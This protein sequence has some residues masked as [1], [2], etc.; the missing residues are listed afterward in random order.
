MKMMITMMITVV[1]SKLTIVTDDLPFL[2]EKK[3][4][5]R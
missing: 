3:I 1:L 2:H 5:N 4:Y